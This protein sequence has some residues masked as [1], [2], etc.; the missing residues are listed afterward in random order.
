VRVAVQVA[1]GEG[2]GVAAVAVGE[3][4]GGQSPGSGVPWARGARA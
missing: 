2:R 1:V 3:G 4:V